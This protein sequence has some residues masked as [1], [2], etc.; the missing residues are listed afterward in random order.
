MAVCDTENLV[1][2]S[3]VFFFIF[4]NNTPNQNF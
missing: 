1:D 2:G 4:G 3:P